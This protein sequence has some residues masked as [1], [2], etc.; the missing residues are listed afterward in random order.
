[1]TELDE[2]RARRVLLLTR[3]ALQRERLALQLAAWEAP[4]AWADRSVAAARSIRR[5][6]QWLLVAAAVFAV[7]RPRR[8]FAWARNGLIVW[9]AWRW[10][11]ATLR[12]FA[13]R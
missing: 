3:A 11:A 1:M 4:L 13:P 9:R 6:P 7:L 12:Q 5:H 2:I 8:A 10:A